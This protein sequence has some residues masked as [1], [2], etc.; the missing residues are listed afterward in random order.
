[1]R[2][3]RRQRLRD[4]IGKLVCGDCVPYVEEEMAAPFEDAARLPIT[5]HLVGKEHRTELAGY[6]IKALI[7][8]RQSERIGLSPCD[9]AIMRPLLRMIEHRL[10][11]VGCH[12]ARLCGKPRCH[13]SRQDTGSG[14][15]FQ[16]FPG[17]NPGEPLGEVAR[18]RLEDEGNQES[19]VGF[20]DR[21]R[22]L[23]VSRRHVAAPSNDA[24][25]WWI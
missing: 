14:G 1:M 10:I 2:K 15:R 22:E 9:P 13:R 6:D 16:D 5:L 11:E 20:R 4:D 24:L 18:V 3:Q 17:F 23:L 8:E 25:V 19:I 7:F 21:S 12:N